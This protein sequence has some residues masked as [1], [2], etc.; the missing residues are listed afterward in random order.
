MSEPYFIGIAGGSGSGKTFFLNKL[1]KDFRT[2]S[3]CFISLDD[4][5]LPRNLQK[6]DEEG[7]KN[8]DLPESID[9]ED[10]YKDILRLK[11]NEEVERTEYTF[12]ND[13]AEAGK[14]IYLPSKVYIIEGLFVY[15]YSEIRKLFDLKLYIEAKENI[16]VIRRIKR[17]RIE[18][19][20]DLEDVLYRYEHHVLPSYEK[21]IQPYKAFAD[22][23]INNND[24]IDEAY[25]LVKTYLLTKL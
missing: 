25:E 21:Y 16:K 18:R 19:N 9:A 20:Y 11:N 22:I 17:D 2:S 24:T 3:V 5:Y 10:L 8:F 14:I 7:V 6:T 13:E 1:K 15:H 23:V 4:Y 12:N